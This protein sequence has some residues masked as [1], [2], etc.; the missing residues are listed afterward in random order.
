M[1][2]NNEPA[3]AKA[4]A[5]REA[6]QWHQAVDIGYSVVAAEPDRADAWALLALILPQ[7]R[8]LDDAE[9]AALRA[10]AIEPQNPVAQRALAVIRIR[11]QRLGEAIPLAEG[12]MALAPGCPQAMVVLGIVRMAEQRLDEAD[13][14]FCQA[15]KLA[16]SAEAHAN[17]AQLQMRRNDFGAAIVHGEAA[18]AKKPFLVGIWQMLARLYLRVGRGDDAIAALERAARLEPDNAMILVELGECYHLAGRQIEALDILEHATA[19]FPGHANA[20]A[21]LGIAQ[22][23]VARI[24]DARTSYERALAIDP[25]QGEVYNNLGAIYL[26]TG[27]LAHAQIAFESACR[28][29]PGRADFYANWGIA[30]VREGKWEL[31]L[32][33]IKGSLRI[34]ELPAA[35]SA[36]V[37][38]A[39]NLG[40]IQDDDENRSLIVRA[41]SEPWGRP[42]DLAA[43]SINLLKPDR[44]IREAI[45]RAMLAWP[46]RL[47][48][49]ELF[50]KD[51]LRAFFENPVLRCLMETIPVCD[52]GLEQFLTMV[53]KNLLRDAFNAAGSCVP[54]D[55]ELRFYCSL[56]RQCFIN[57]YVFS[58]EAG[59]IEIADLLRVEIERMLES[60]GDIPVL[61]LVALASYFPLC[62]LPDAALLL[63][64]AWPDVVSELLVVQVAEPLTEQR[65][66]ADI[67][68][69]TAIEDEVSILVQRQYEEN[70][71]PKWTSLPATVG[72]MAVEDYLRLLFPLV[73]FPSAGIDDRANILVA[74][75]GTGQHPI[76][77]AQRFRKSKVL[78]VDLSL[79]SL[80]YAVRK[81][82][83]LGLDNIEYMQADIM[84]L[85]SSDLQF[86]VIESVGVLHHLRDP[87]AGWKILCSMLRPGGFMRL[88]F[89]S[90]LARKDIDSAKRYIEQCG[91]TSNASD[92]R[93]CRQDIVAM[94]D[95]EMAK[96]VTRRRDFFET[97]S[98]RDLL[99][100]CQEHLFTLP[101]I[102]HAL[103]LLDLIF[104]GFVLETPAIGSSYRSRFPGDS[105]MT[106]LDFWDMFEAD[107]PD[108]FK[109]MYQFWVQKPT[110]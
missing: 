27:D 94:A 30:L 81:T 73:L 53:R 12:A 48:K 59:E 40:N 18:V 26:Q 46:R 16:Q 1:T 66:R 19:K 71:Y 80:G 63:G 65:Y 100:H 92:I 61:K 99:F 4:E 89:Y 49:R 60:S 78:A 93:R 98:C 23:Q 101:Q 37:Q 85:S 76:E 42:G 8:M 58:Y 38:C 62:S 106:N 10:L 84:K 21:T 86:D 29:L 72:D 44:V 39:K 35:K 109:G 95:S 13:A 17:R 75:C 50:E 25:N 55:A 52:I 74:G 82:R 14:L 69:L 91:Y 7:L 24:S 15:I 11:Q 54:D 88:G 68:R 32:D 102:K 34:K 104:I 28:Q 90:D 96:Q 41:M 6:G 110:H 31:A 2:D 51:G 33:A 83:E 105:Q 45:G 77:T 43:V 9:K 107:N 57:E 20:W 22:Q 3:L 87:L 67:K 47:E 108:T 5:L 56:A 64:R 97:S 36:F 79:T 103:E 70:P